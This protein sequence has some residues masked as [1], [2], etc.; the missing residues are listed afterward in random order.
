MRFLRPICLAVCL[1]FAATAASAADLRI[2]VASEVTTLDPHFFHLTSNTE[3]HKAIYSGL[4]TQDADMKVVPDLAVSWRTIDD[5]H[6]EFKLRPGV[7][8][9]DGT[10]LTADDVVF[11]Y[12]RARSVP[13]SPGSFLQYLKH[14]T[15]TVAADP[16]R[17]IVE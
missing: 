6:W 4:V 8:F 11:T 15:Q 3:I 17:V 16:L 7:I 14:V 2:G 10:P 12:E 1:A 13:N 9:H 5:T